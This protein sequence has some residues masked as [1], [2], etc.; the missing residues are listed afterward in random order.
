MECFYNL[1]VS[2]LEVMEDMHPM[3][4]L[5]D[6]IFTF[7]CADRP[8]L[9]HYD[10]TSPE[11]QEDFV[12]D[13]MVMAYD[14]RLLEEVWIDCPWT[15]LDA[16][17]LHVERGLLKLVQEQYQRNRPTPGTYM[18]FNKAKGPYLPYPDTK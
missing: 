16:F 13:L 12:Q 9:V 4:D 11:T 3:A 10:S 7:E 5:C 14:M 6:K 8:L 15:A 1:L 17:M 2:D 18:L